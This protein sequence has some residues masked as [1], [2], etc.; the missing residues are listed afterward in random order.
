MMGVPSFATGGNGIEI[1]KNRCVTVQ[2]R[3]KDAWLRR[4]PHGLSNISILQ[5]KRENANT[6]C[7][8]VPSIPI[9][10]SLNNND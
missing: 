10:G 9:T 8:T 2:K 5:T 3:Q 4:D 6:C 1:K 7:M